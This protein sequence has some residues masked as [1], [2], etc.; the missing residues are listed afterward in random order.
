M[1]R[2]PNESFE[3]YKIRQKLES[4][5]KQTYRLLWDSSIKGTYVCAKHGELI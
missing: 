3:D 5:K 2:K 4:N 1:K